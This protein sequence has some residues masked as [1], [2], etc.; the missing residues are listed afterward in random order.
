[1]IS[2]PLKRL[3]QSFSVSVFLDGL[4]AARPTSIAR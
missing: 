4:Q 3:I 1:L 2:F